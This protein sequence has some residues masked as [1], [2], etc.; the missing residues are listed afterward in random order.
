[1][2]IVENINK[3]SSILELV[4]ACFVNTRLLNKG[5]LSAEVEKH[6]PLTVSSFRLEG[7]DDKRDKLTL[8][9]ADGEVTAVVSWRPSSTGTGVVVDQIE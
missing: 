1:M 8:G 6:L 2:K 9:F 3:K 7:I 5:D 4:R